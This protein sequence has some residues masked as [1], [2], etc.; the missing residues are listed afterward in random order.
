MKNKIL[1]VAFLISFTFVFIQLTHSLSVSCEVGGPY[2]KN[3]SANLSINLAGSVTNPAGAANITANVTKSGVLK[4]S[5]T[6]TADS[7]GVYFKTISHNLDVG[8]YTINVSAEQ[9]GTYAFCDDTL[10][11]QIPQTVSACVNRNLRVSGKAV[12]SS[13]GE[14]LS[15]GKI[16]ASILEENLSNSTSFT[17]GD[18]TIYVSSCLKGGKKYTL[19]IIIE[20]SVGSR[21]WLYSTIT[22]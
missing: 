5:K 12:S 20:N 10:E 8:T 19:Q 16:F 6:T 4:V 11:V 17:N 7:Q 18:F 2:L 9:Q 14:L 13:T 21:S 3:S 22:W 15:S 1:F